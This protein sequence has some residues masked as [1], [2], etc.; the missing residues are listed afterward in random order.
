M[1]A[2]FGRHMDA[3][4]ENSRRACGPA[5]SAG[6]PP[7]CAFFWLLF[8][9][10][11]KKSDSR[12]SAKR[13]CLAVTTFCT[14]KEVQKLPST[15]IRMSRRMHDASLILSAHVFLLSINDNIKTDRGAYTASI[16]N[17]ADMR[18]KHCIS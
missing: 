15:D 6:V 7:G 1:C 17:C 16:P 2:V 18:K 10:Q 4:P 8:F 5:R 14:W 9:A 11:A 12:E 13:Y 3:R